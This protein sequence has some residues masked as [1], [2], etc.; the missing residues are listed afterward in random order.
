MTLLDSARLQ[1]E[2]LP[3]FQPPSKG[4]CTN[5][6]RNI[7]WIILWKELVDPH[8]RA[9]GRHP[10]LFP[11][12]QQSRTPRLSPTSLPTPLSQLTPTQGLHQ[13]LPPLQLPTVSLQLP[14]H[15]P[16]QAPPPQQT[17]VPQRPVLLPQ[18]PP[19]VPLQLRQD[20]QQPRLWLP[21]MNLQ[22]LTPTTTTSANPSQNSKVVLS[23]S[24]KAKKTWRIF[25]TIAPSSVKTQMIAMMRTSQLFSHPTE[26]L[27]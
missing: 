6:Q 7:L 5:Y 16:S 10:R 25:W 23:T 3:P 4:S 1:K 11:N 13:P 20:H 27:A 14:H 24:R 12:L 18:R 15:R 22:N 19:H 26:F 8:L 17:Q 9:Q 2:K 21:F